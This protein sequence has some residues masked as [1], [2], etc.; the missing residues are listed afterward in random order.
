MRS[1]HLAIHSTAY[2]GI[3]L[4]TGAVGI[5]IYLLVH[6][7]AALHDAGILAVQVGDALGDGHLA[8]LCPVGFAVIAKEA[9]GGHIIVGER[10]ERACGLCAHLSQ[11]VAEGDGVVGRAFVLTRAASLLE[12]PLLEELAHGLG[13]GDDAERLARLG[14]RTHI[15][16]APVYQFACMRQRFLTGI[17]GT[18]HI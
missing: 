2:F 1:A 17:A 16:I 11:R 12:L 9:D 3:L 7:S 13:M 6:L 10:D 14:R 8:V 15:V 4:A 5:V 18:H